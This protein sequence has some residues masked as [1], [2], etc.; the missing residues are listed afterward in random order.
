[1]RLGAQ[2]VSGVFSTIGT[3]LLFWNVWAAAAFYLLPVVIAVG[4]L[5]VIVTRAFTATRADFATPA[6]PSIRTPLPAGTPLVVRADINPPSQPAAPTEPVP[7]PE[8]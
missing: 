3:T 1:M 4:W 6:A 7:S 2:I 8:S 5:G